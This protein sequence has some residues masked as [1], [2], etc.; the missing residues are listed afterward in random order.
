MAECDAVE[1]TTSEVGALLVVRVPLTIVV[2]DPDAVGPTDDGDPVWNRE[3]KID[4][5]RGIACVERSSRRVPIRVPCRRFCGIPR[6]ELA[7]G[8]VVVAGSEV[9]EPGFGVR[10]LVEG[11][12]AM[13]VPHPSEAPDAILVIS[14]PSN[15]I[16]NGKPNDRD[17]GHRAKQLPSC[18]CG[19][20]DCHRESC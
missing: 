2:V 8:G 20:R 7:G 12:P 4:H 3:R 14:A 18:E 13:R 19:R 17:E 5:P 1:H 9:L 16:P 11:M 10:V 6:K 15:P